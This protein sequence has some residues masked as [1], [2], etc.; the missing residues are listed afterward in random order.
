MSSNTGEPRGAARVQVCPI[1]DND[2]PEVAQLLGTH[3]PP[4]TPLDRWAEVWRETVNLPDSSAPNHG[5][6]LRAGGKVVGAYPAV[7]S[8]R[9][10][11]GRTERFCNLAVWYTEPQYRLHSVRMVKA[12]LVQGGWH[13]TDLT[14]IDVV[15]QLNLRLGFRFLDTT[16]VLIPNIPWPSV[17]G[18]VRV[19]ADEAVIRASLNGQP[20][21][22]FLDHVR[23][24]WA[25]HLVVVR[26]GEACYVQWRMERRKGLPVFASL[27]YASNPTVLRKTIRPLGHYL[28]TRYGALGTVVELRVAGGRPRPSW[29]LRRSKARMFKSDTLAP[30][31]VDYL[32]S[33]ITSV[34]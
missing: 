32:Y 6:L 16:A 1:T 19:S 17:R 24:Q 14:P 26:D 33:E 7:Y 20:L 11:N 22:F 28:L 10:I 30:E 12:I 5:F 13:F 34:P 3:F 8:T 25:R 9:V 18:R 15:Q 31:D 21:K 29:Q 4:D 27:R 23:C 2:L